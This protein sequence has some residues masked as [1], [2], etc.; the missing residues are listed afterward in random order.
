MDMELLFI[1][2]IPL[3]KTLKIAQIPVVVQ[4]KG[5]PP[6]ITD[7]GVYVFENLAI[8]E[9]DWVAAKSQ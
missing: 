9:W 8:R 7:A 2:N 4:E 5:M 6:I 3:H 1:I